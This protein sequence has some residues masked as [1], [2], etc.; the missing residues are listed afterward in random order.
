MS[1]QLIALPPEEVQLDEG[2]FPDRDDSLIFEHLLHYCSLLETLPAVRVLV[3]WEQ[4]VI[5]RGHKYLRI[6]LQLGR[7]KI[8]AVI[9]PSSVANAVVMLKSQPGVEKMDWDEIDTLERATPMV[10]QWHVF[11]FERPLTKEEKTHFEIDV[12]HFFE[13]L[14]HPTQ[15]EVGASS[16]RCIR[17]DDQGPSAE[18]LTRTPVGDES[19]YGPY[20]AV[21]KRFSSEIVRVVSYQGRRFD[22]QPTT[23]ED[24]VDEAG[25]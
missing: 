22:G 18:F 3:D 19:W 10:D 2:R 6:A 1:I 20:F 8:R 17:Y 15:A 11:F 16:V 24:P 21:A 25:Q 7:S 12:V 9:D 14:A 23:H 13:G 5:T 4:V